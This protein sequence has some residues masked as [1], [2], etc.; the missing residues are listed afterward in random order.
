MRKIV[1]LVMAVIGMVSQVDCS[2][3][4]SDFSD[5]NILTAAQLNAWKSQR[6]GHL[7]PID[8]SPT[9][10]YVNSTWDLGSTSYRWQN[11]WLGSS[12]K[13]DFNTHYI[14]AGTVSGNWNIVGNTFSVSTNTIVVTSNKLGV[15]KTPSWNF[16][17]SG[18]AGISGAAIV[19][20]GIDAGNNGQYVKMKV[21]PFS[22]WNMNSSGQNPRSVAHGLTNTKILGCIA[23]VYRNDGTKSGQFGNFNANSNVDIYL[24][25]TDGTN[26]IM[27]RVNGSR[28]DNSN[29]NNASGYI[30]VFYIP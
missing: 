12:G 2:D 21:I 23:T 25:E 14:S 22:G 26:I 16:D 13:L 1:I 7:L 18:N 10:N 20:G 24:D 30:L 5:G 8:P 11:L 29:Y 19:N 28:F 27:Y 6:D 15:G 9:F 4:P 17:V 3:L